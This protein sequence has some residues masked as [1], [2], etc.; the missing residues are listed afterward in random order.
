MGM[1]IKR[2]PSK[3]IDEKTEEDEAKQKFMIGVKREMI[4][5]RKEW[6]MGQKYT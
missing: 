1:R 5:G 4:Q 2:K 3:S 6:G